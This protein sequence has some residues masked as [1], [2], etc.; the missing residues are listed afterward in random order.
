MIAALPSQEV[1]LKN[2]RP[3]ILGQVKGPY[4]LIFFLWEGLG[5]HL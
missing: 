5:E 1:K 3:A 2:I 4:R